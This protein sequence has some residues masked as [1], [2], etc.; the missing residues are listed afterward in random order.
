MDT[1]LHK[2]NWNDDSNFIK[3]PLNGVT[4]IFFLLLI[5]FSILF[6]NW[7]FGSYQLRSPVIVHIQ[8]PWEPR[9]V[10]KDFNPVNA[11]DKTRKPIPSPTSKPSKSVSFLPQVQAAELTIDDYI[12]NAKHADIIRKIYKLESSEG[13]NDGCKDKGKL[14]GFGYGQSTFV[15]NCFDSAEEVVTKV[16]KWFDTQLKT[17]TLAESLCYYNIGVVTGNCDYYKNYKS[18]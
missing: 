15:W 7:F 17:K 10:K 2:L 14:N 12:N 8:A 5:M 1:K 3:I 13:R 11:E 18:L 6:G 4:T 16:D 9:G